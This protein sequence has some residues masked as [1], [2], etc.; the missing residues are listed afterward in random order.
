MPRITADRLLRF[1]ERLHGRSLKTLH[2]KKSFKIE[3]RGDK[4]IYTPRSTGKERPHEKVVLERI[5][6][7]FNNTHP[8]RQFMPSH[9]VGQRTVNA[10]YTLAL[11]RTYLDGKR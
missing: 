11:I 9:Y 4:L 10:S 7:E 1:A 8:S 5:C 2:R 6:D 3:V